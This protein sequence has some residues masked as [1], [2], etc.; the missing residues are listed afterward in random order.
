MQS[1]EGVNLF[2]TIKLPIQSLSS[3]QNAKSV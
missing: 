3:I 2:E 1:A